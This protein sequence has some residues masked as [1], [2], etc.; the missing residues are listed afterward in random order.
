MICKNKGRQRGGEWKNLRPESGDGQASEQ[1][2]DSVVRRLKVNGI[3]SYIRGDSRVLIGVDGCDLSEFR[4]QKV[5]GTL[6]I[7][8]CPS[9]YIK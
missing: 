5:P 8:A 7:L 3:S 2:F 4:Y 9:L 6:I 1:P